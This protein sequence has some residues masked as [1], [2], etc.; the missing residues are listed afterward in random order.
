MAAVLSLQFAMLQI[1]EIIDSIEMNVDASRTRVALYIDNWFGHSILSCCFFFR[2]SL[3]DS[4]LSFF[5]LFCVT[6]CTMTVQILTR[7]CGL[8]AGVV[9][10]ISRRF[11]EQSLHDS[12]LES[13]ALSEW[14]ACFIPRLLLYDALNGAIAVKYR[15]NK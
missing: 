15:L 6:F 5:A 14:T 12:V 1:P 10:A 2:F 8:F 11:E 13:S 3:L 4:L 9:S 7:T